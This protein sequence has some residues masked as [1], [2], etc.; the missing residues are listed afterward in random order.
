M[1]KIHGR[2]K[3]PVILAIELV[4]WEA[5]EDIAKGE[6]DIVSRVLRAVDEISHITTTGDLEGI[7]DWFS[8]RL[9]LAS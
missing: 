1:W 4:L 9:V 3:P 6:K 8:G 5:I 7:E 2:E